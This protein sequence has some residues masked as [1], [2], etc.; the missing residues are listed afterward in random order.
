MR[1][2]F[3]AAERRQKSP[4]RDHYNFHRTNAAVHIDAYRIGI[5]AKCEVDR[6]V[7]DAQIPDVEFVE[8]IWKHRMLELQPVLRR[9]LCHSQAGLKHHI[10]CTRRP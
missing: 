1:V 6:G 9:I 2:P 3:K 8:E 5:T 10:D 4:L 7:A